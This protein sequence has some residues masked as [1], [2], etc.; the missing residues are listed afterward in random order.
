MKKH[1]LKIAGILN[2]LTA[3]IHLTGGQT[4]LINPLTKSNLD[5]QT[6]GELVGAWHIVSIVLFMTSYILIK[7]SFFKNTSY[8]KDLLKYIGQSYVLFGIPF[9]VISLWFSILAPQWILLIP[10]GLLTLTGLRT[11]SSS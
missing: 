6:I 10:I 8:S 5:T 3:L 9:I 4:T 2:L 1:F 7:S 11:T